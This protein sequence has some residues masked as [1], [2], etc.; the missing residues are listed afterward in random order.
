MTRRNHTGGFLLFEAMIAVAMLA[1]GILALG[2]CVQNCLVAD[3][4]KEDDARARRFLANRMAEIEANSVVTNDKQTEKL[5]GEFAGMVLQTSKLPLKKKNEK[6][7]ELFGI[8]AITLRL[9]WEVDGS[10]QTKE[11]SFYVYPRQR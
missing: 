4:V 8:F 1:I 5:K 2:S 11:L 9:N 3:R 7:V 10:E 6:G